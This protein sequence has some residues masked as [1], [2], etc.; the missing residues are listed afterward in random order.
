MCIGMLQVGFILLLLVGRA[1]PWSSCPKG[2]V[3]FPGS[4]SPMAVVL[5][6]GSVASDGS[7]VSATPNGERSYL[8]TSCDVHGDK[9]W[10]NLLNVKPLGKILSYTVDLSSAGCNCNAALYLVSMAQQ[11]TFK[12]KKADCKGDPTYCDANGVCGSKCSEIDLMEANNHAFVTTIHKKTGKLVRPLRAL[13]Y[14]VDTYNIYPMYC[15]CRS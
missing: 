7:I 9:P 5:N 3:A 15:L 10:D 1:N 14:Y 8:G 13:L 4:G 12:S 2:S 11:R 6:G